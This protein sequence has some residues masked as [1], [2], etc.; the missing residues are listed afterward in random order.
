MNSYQKRV[1]WVLALIGLGY[2]SLFIFPNLKG[3]SDANMLAVFETD[4]FAQYPHVIG[5]LTPGATFYQSIRNFA[6]YLHYY[7]GYPFYFFSALVI[8]PLKLF[9]GSNW[10]LATPVIVLFLRQFINVLP[11]ILAAAWMV[12]IQT[13][14]R[15][16]WHAVALFLVLLSIPALVV[17]NFW[18]HPDSLLV[19][20]VVLTFFF[21]DRDQLRFGP[22]FFLAAA[23]CG[24]A[25]G[26]KHLGLFFFLAIPIYL[27]FGLLKKKIQPFRALGLGALFIGVMAAAVVLSNPLLLLP[28]ER[29]EIIA[30]QKLQWQQSTQGYWTQN[31]SPYF[32]W[33]QYPEDFRQHYGELFF[34]MLCL[35]GLALG[36]LREDRRRLHILILAW[37][38]PFMYYFLVIATT[39]RTHYFL[40]VAIPL[41]SCLINFFPPAF[42]NRL[43]RPDGAAPPISQQI[44]RIARWAAAVL[45]IVQVGIFL[46]KD[47]GLYRD[48]LNK[49]KDSSSLVF[50]QKV[51]KEVLSKLEGQKL[52]IYHDWKAYIPLH[53][54]W[55][56]EMNW[57]LANYNYIRDL[58]PDILLLEN[59]NLAIFTPENVVQNAL[60]PGNMAA[61]HQFYADAAENKIPGYQRVLQDHFGSVFVKD[62]LFPEVSTP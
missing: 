47:I 53:S 34:I 7:Y 11:M 20:F 19:L 46:W 6:V 55:Q 52:V 33:G 39:R 61:L 40:P 54:G 21:L 59:G 43:D 48:Q 4:E 12:W 26:T 58:N 5:M 1:L 32:Q 8:L 29:A 62:S 28:Q 49:E 36:M 23:A 38:V 42:P 15:S 51:E 31:L 10:T 3:A 41:F 60:N 18:W 57:D 13:R 50:S 16:I 45:I 25:T 30:T 22:N 27:G 24:L 17:N 56:M 9:L 2:F 14:F 44:M 37:V 35:L